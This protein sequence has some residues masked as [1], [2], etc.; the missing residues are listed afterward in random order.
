MLPVATLPAAALLQG[1]GLLD[2]EKDLHLGS[3]IG[4][5][6]NQ[7]VA[8]FLNAGSGAI[9]GNLAL[10]FAVGVAIGF[11]GDAVAAL[12]ALI[13]YMVLTKVLLIV[14]GTFSFI[15]D[16]VVLDMGVL[17]GSLPVHGPLSCTKS[18]TISNCQIGSA[19]SQANGLFLLLLQPR[20]W[21]WQSSLVWSGARYKMLSVISVTG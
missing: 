4:G 5:F 20:Q 17:G 6:L 21:Y 13:A 2:Y 1:L 11:A 7:Y 14:P 10:I 12:S 9:F 3:T 16:D 8:P 19:S 15:G 18:I